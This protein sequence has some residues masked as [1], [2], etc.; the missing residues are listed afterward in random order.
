MTTKVVYF[1]KKRIDTSRTVHLWINTH[2]LETKKLLSE[3]QLNSGGPLPSCSAVG[4]KVG[5]TSRLRT[6]ISVNLDRL[7]ELKHIYGDGPLQQQMQA[8]EEVFITHYS[9]IPWEKN[10]ISKQEWDEMGTNYKRVYQHD[11]VFSVTKTRP[12]ET[13]SLG[14]FVLGTNLPADDEIRELLESP[15]EPHIPTHIPTHIPD[16]QKYHPKNSTWGFSTKDYEL[17]PI[18]VSYIPT[19]RNRMSFK[20]YL[21]YQQWNLLNLDYLNQIKEKGLKEGLNLKNEKGQVNKAFYTD[22]MFQRLEYIRLSSLLK[23]F[24]DLGFTHVNL[25]D[26]A[27]RNRLLDETGVPAPENYRLDRQESMEERRIAQQMFRE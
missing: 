9:S 6:N 24:G 15:Y 4:Q 8:A 10:I 18:E 13:H 20:Q 27:C 5:F 26:T 23:L 22:G 11:R 17:V 12:T 3:I 25:F 1:L 19:V 2:G 16:D 7:K 21:E 14:I